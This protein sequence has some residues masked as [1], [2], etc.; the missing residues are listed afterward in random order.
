MFAQDH[1]LVTPHLA[2]DA[3]VRTESQQL[4][5]TLRLA[6]RA[7]LAWTPFTD[8]GPVIRAGAGLFYDRVPLD[9][10][11]F[12]QFP[13]R[14]VTTYDGAGNIIRGPISIPECAWH[15]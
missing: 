6:P 2:F 12:S 1:W 13:E 5:E 7:G 11:S 10:F 8:H 3:G 14:V 4:T 9:V 15:C